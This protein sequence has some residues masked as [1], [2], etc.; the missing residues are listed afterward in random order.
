MPSH[1]VTLSIGPAA[2]FE[3]TLND[4]PF[5]SKRG[6]ATYA[7]DLP[8]EQDVVPGANK[9]V[10]TI[11]AAT[12]TPQDRPRTL[13]AAKG[14]YAEAAV[15][16]DHVVDHGAT[17]TARP[18]TLAEVSWHPSED[19]VAQV[20]LPHRI[21]L[22]FQAAVT[23]GPV[24]LD[25]AAIAAGSADAEAL[26][27]IGTLAGLLRAGNIAEAT[28]ALRLKYQDMAR[29]FPLFGDAD[30]I[31]SIDQRMIRELLAT[32]GATIPDPATLAPKFPVHAGRLVEALGGDGEPL[33]RIT[34]PGA[35]PV[36]LKTMLA[37]I[38]GQLVPVR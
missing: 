34:R 22:S 17:V 36:Y 3:A 27:V 28:Q 5:A 20:T 9:V 11:G 13:P 38:G 32:P 29:A 7:S 14:L 35:E 33:L 12:G 37:R 8:I 31:R 15:R 25:G 19:G 24:W 21:E 16:V 26:H 2:S 6:T 1:A 18:E 10:I 4:V 23:R 30:H